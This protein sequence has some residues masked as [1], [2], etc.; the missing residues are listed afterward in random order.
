MRRGEIERKLDEIVAFAEV[1]KFI[2]TPVKRYSSG[3]YLRL[4]FA[5]A[6]HLEPEILVID[7][8]LAVGDAEFQRKCLGKMSEV[9]KEGRTVL[10][11]SHNMSAILNLTKRTIV[12]DQGQVVFEAESSEAVDHYLSSGFSQTGERFWRLEEVPEQAKPFRPIALRVKNSEGKI[13]DTARSVEPSIVEFEYALDEPIKG[14][15]VGIYLTTTLGEYVLNSFDI[16]EQKKF[17]E[18]SSRPAGYYIS[19]CTIPPDVLNGGQYMIT[20]LASVFRVKIYFREDG[21]LNFNVDITGAPGS[22]WPEKRPG[23]IRPRLKWQ[24]EEISLNESLG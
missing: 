18:Y 16:D 20:V 15:R 5:V 17:E 12:L 14:L 13:V 1:E 2:D 11:V 9:S 6:A 7:E 22:H 10:F 8:V 21:A 3:M 23:A 24:I 4:A 19:R